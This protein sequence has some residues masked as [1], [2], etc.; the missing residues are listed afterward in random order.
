[1][2]VPAVWPATLVVLY[3]L[4]PAAAAA[5]LG[6]WPLTPAGAAALAIALSLAVLA[7]FTGSVLSPNRW[8]ILLV[9]LIA[10]RI[11]LSA[12]AAE[13]GWQGKYYVNDAWSGAPEWSSDYRLKDATRIDR[14]L[15]FTAGELPTHF[16]NGAAY[17]SGNER[18]V[19]EPLT[20]EW[21]GVFTLPV[22]TTVALETAVNGD[23][24]IMIDDVEWAVTT[25]SA[26]VQR[27]LESGLHSAVVR[28]R[29]P[30]GVAG[31]FSL[32][33]R[34]DS[35][36]SIVVFPPGGNSKHTP[37]ADALAFAVDAAVV[38]ILAG[39]AVLTM[40][41][42][43]YSPGRV[44]F[45][46][47]ALTLVALGVQGFV[48]ALPNARQFRSL[49][50]GDDWL[51]FESRA[52]D[53][54]Q[55]GPLMTLGQP[56]GEGAAYFYHPL[57]S[58]LLAAVHAVAGESLFGPVFVH[59]LILAVTALIM[60]SLTRSVFGAVPAT[61]GLLALVI[62]FEIDFIRYYTVT[63]LS[64]NLY[65]LTV[66]L[67][68]AAFAAWG[69]TGRV[70]MLVQAG[71][72]G[73]VSAVTR[74][75]MMIFLVPALLVTSAMAFR[76]RG[77]SWPLLAPAIAG[78]AWLAVVLPFTLRNW[79]V[80]KKLVLISDGLGGAMVVLNVPP[81]V[82]PQPYLAGYN[83]GIT[84]SIGV[85][86]RLFVEHPAGVVALQIKKLGFTLGMVHWFDGY[87]VHPELIAA[88]ALY[89]AMLICSRQMRSAALWPLHAFVVSHWA[90]MALTS[91]WNYG[92]RMI[93]PPYVYTTTL[94][95]AAAVALAWPHLPRTV[96]Q[97]A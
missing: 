24:R 68:L 77:G 9:L 61:F 45:A 31:A 97:P 78:A 43:W 62:L 91:P 33:L 81:G 14:V 92:Y 48:T 69:R 65:V 39:I 7:R 52:R 28:Y 29:K 18:H 86:W 44:P 96:R 2:R 32:D 20:I 6:A 36:Q 13:S 95:V 49:S 72:W 73:G 71:L 74:P 88:T 80:A 40:R 75:A 1:M 35:L 8:S 56:I 79:L 82:D 85:L 34:S 41:S 12:A 3:L 38:I 4:M 87:R 83:G 66:T 19:S 47:G 51:G 5:P 37:I 15:T 84:N 67:C 59:F 55:N 70:A 23:A 76:Q 89:L 46:I 26:S 10:M 17:P 54:L 21:R 50:S 60:W 90:S 16:L 25:G 64:E 94:A 11:G 63:L 53:I 30:A 22:P 93:L 57:Y 27:R 42:A 58:Y